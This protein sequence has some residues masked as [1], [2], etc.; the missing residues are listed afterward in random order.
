M[1]LLNTLSFDGHKYELN[2]AK[3]F[4][5]PGR[6]FKMPVGF[7]GGRVDKLAK[8]SVKGLYMCMEGMKPIDLIVL[9][10]PSLRK[11]TLEKVLEAKRI[12]IPAKATKADLIEILK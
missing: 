12:K 4:M 8:T 5:F 3:G 7:Y 11:A 9:D 2:D 6:D 1:I 10:A